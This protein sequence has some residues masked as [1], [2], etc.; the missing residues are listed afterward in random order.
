VPGTH[1]EELLISG[2]SPVTRERTGLLQQVGSNRFA[3]IIWVGDGHQSRA[4]RT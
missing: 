1:R 2:V 3:T 4:I